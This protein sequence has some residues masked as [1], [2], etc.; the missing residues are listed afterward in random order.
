MDIIQRDILLFPAKI[1]GVNPIG[2]GRFDV[3]PI[4]D[5]YVDVRNLTFRG[6]VGIMNGVVTMKDGFRFIRCDAICFRFPRVKSNAR[7]VG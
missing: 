2:V 3:N 1:I 6:T 7:N 5:G 4:D